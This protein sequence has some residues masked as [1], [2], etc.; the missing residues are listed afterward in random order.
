[1]KKEFLDLTLKNCSTEDYHFLP[2]ISYS[3]L[4]RFEKEGPKSLI[5]QNKKK[6][7]Y[8]KIGNMVDCILTDTEEFDN[9]FYKVPQQLPS[10]TIQSI[11]IDIL[12]NT[13]ITELKD[14]PETFILESCNKFNYYLNYNT[15]TRISKILKAE[16][17]NLFYSNIVQNVNKEGITIEEYNTALQV[18][19]ELYTN[20]FTKNIF[21]ETENTDII[22]QPKIIID[23]LCEEIIKIMPDIIVINNKDKTITI[24][25]LK[26]TNY[27]ETDFNKSFINLNYYLQGTLY[28]QAVQF[29]LS[30]NKAFNEYTLQ[31]FTFVVVNVVNL[32]PMLYP[33]Y[34]CV[35]EEDFIVFGNIKKNWKTIVNEIIW[36]KTNNEYKYT[37]ELLS[38]NGKSPIM[39]RVKE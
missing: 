21:I 20:S 28:Y 10:E 23:G 12:E 24:Y 36:H 29:I 34:N 9:K 7:K 18:R 31:P 8:M 35:N 4:S 15:S 5:T 37:R 39:M 27:D 25:D 26:V 19:Y 13:A 16:E 11:L 30:K 6:T 17:N 14:V 3:L 2:Y 22:F 33:F 38:N 32:A 1:M